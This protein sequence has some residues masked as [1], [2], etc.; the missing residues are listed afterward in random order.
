MNGTQRQANQA[1]PPPEEDPDRVLWLKAQDEYGK[2]LVKSR[3]ICPQGAPDSLLHVCARGLLEHFQA[4]RELKLAMTRQKARR[5]AQPPRQG[6]TP[7]IPVPLCPQC[8][9]PVYDN[10]QDKTSPGAPDF[11]CKRKQCVDAMGKQYAGWLDSKKPGGVRWAKPYRPGEGGDD[12]NF[13]E[14]YDD[15]DELPF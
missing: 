8:E 7:A 2:A 10:R 5:G 11:R 6:P 4:L 3:A 14:G 13:P 15:E 1:P 12:S 9:G